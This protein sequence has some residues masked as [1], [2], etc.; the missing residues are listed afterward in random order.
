MTCRGEKIALQIQFV[1]ISFTFGFCSCLDVKFYEKMLFAEA[2]YVI[3]FS[4]M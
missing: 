4:T 1:N 2:K 3:T